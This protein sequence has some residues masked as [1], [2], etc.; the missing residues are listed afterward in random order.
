MEGNIPISLK[1]D[2][3]SLELK[4]FLKIEKYIFLNLYN[5]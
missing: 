3:T 5:L 1:A 2:D 4:N